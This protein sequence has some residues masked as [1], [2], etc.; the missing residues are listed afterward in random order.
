MEDQ[1]RESIL[2]Q[3]EELKA[4]MPERKNF[5]DEEEFEE[6]KAGWMASRGRVISSLLGR[7]RDF[8]EK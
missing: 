7:L 8:P 6:T 4:T 3:I 5:G 2:A 1:T